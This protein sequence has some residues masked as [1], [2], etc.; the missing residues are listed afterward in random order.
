MAQIE[1]GELDPREIYRAGE[2]LFRSG[3][4]PG[5]NQNLAICVKKHLG[6]SELLN[7]LVL[8][9]SGGWKGGCSVMVSPGLSY[10]G[11]G[12]LRFA[13]YGTQINPKGYIEIVGNTCSPDCRQKYGAPPTFLF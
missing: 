9:D 7:D 5:G 1:S 12:A 3:A 13:P 10:R 4:C 2:K 6:K 8:R 11:E